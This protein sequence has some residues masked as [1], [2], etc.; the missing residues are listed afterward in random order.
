[1]DVYH[2]WFN[3]KDGVGDGE[4]ADT[5]RAYLDHLR[6]ENLVVG[7]RITRR[8]LGL[9]H[10]NL[11]EWHITLDFT[12]MGQMDRAFGLVSSRADPVEGFHHAVN[13]KVRDIFFALYRD[14]PD[15]GRVR[16]QERF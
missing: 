16:G 15:E 11:P 5:A 4:F 9:G 10:P 1:V 12:D 6:A 14:F 2:I 7:Y 13:S 3:L 8:K